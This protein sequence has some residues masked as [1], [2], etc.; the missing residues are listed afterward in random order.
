MSSGN[1]CIKTSYEDIHQRLPNIF[2]DLKIT[3]RVENGDVVEF[4]PFPF[5]SGS[6]QYAFH[7]RVIEKNSSPNEAS[8]ETEHVVI[9]VP[10]ALDGCTEIDKYCNLEEY[11]KKSLSMRETVRDYAQQFNRLNISKKI[12]FVK[13]YE[14]KIT[15]MP[16]IMIEDDIG[17]AI[18]VLEKVKELFFLRSS[19]IVEHFIEGEF[20]KFLNNDGKPNEN[21][22]SYL[23]GAFAHWT[24][25]KSEGTILISDIQ[26]VKS[27]THYLL[28]DPSIHSNKDLL[29]Q[30]VDFGETDLG[31]EGMIKFFLTN[32]YN[33][34]CQALSLTN[35]KQ[36]S[37]SAFEKAWMSTEVTEK[38]FIIDMREH[39]KLKY[40]GNGPIV[41][42]ENQ[43]KAD[44][45]SEQ[46]TEIEDAD[47]S[48]DV[49]EPG[50]LDTE[51][52]E[53]NEKCGSDCDSADYWETSDSS[54]TVEDSKE[55]NYEGE[56]TDGRKAEKEEVPDSPKTLQTADMDDEKLSLLDNL[57]NDFK[58]RILLFSIDQIEK[59][60]YADARHHEF[61]EL[62]NNIQTMKMKKAISG[63][64]FE[65]VHALQ[66]LLSNIDCLRIFNSILNNE[67]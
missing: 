42:D 20:T 39:M 64:S 47:C 25:E 36:D 66:I 38:Q 65:Q 19:L 27:S 22:R 62:K 29:D 32:E 35:L 16:E 24:W 14:A 5:E 6:T 50:E 48:S 15:H 44:I 21:C 33:S 10:K 63:L 4:E 43:V 18:D 30:V 56:T 9:K 17:D 28:T 31:L 57:G 3:A 49:K 55:E 8:Y 60:T 59:M 54:H 41:G 34:L 53:N 61:I 40:Q 45:S 23:P 37:V 67:E 52:E 51:T 58:T 13:C 12:K 1:A 7:G 46:G 26:G 2:N 11:T